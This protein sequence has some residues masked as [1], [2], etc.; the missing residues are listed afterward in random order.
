MRIQVKPLLVAAGLVNIIGILVFSLGFTN[1]SLT[2]NSP[3][4]FSVFGLISILLWG[5]A[6]I[7]TSYSQHVGPL[8]ALFAVEKAVYVI[9]WVVWISENNH[10][11][12]SVFNES[13]MSGIFYSLYGPIDFGF[14]VAFAL[15]AY[16]ITRHHSQY[17]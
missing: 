8:L 14:A 12:R 3:V 15:S 2:E 11:L 7:A 17:Y 13:V 16:Q 10:R 4:I 1:Q 6:Y 5:A 9:T